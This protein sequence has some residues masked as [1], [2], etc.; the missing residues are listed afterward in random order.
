MTEILHVGSISMFVSEEDNTNSLPW[1][2]HY[3]TES[4]CNETYIMFDH[5]DETSLF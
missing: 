4:V 5:T 1:K 2:W 3:M